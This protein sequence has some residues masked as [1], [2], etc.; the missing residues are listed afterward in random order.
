MGNLKE[1]LRQVKVTG[2]LM[3]VFVIPPAFAQSNKTSHSNS[4]GDVY[5]PSADAIR[6]ATVNSYIKGET[7]RYDA[8]Y[9]NNIN[10]SKKVRLKMKRAADLGTF[11]S[12]GADLAIDGEGPVGLDGN[13]I[14]LHYN[15]IKAERDGR[16]AWG[17]AQTV[18]ATLVYAAEWKKKCIA[19]LTKDKSKLSDANKS[20]TCTLQIGDLSLHHR[21]VDKDTGRCDLGHKS[22]YNGT[23]V[24]VRPAGL[25]AG[26]GQP[27]KVVDLTTEATKFAKSIGAT[28][29]I[30]QAEG[31]YDHFHVC[32]PDR[33]TPDSTLSKNAI[34]KGPLA[35]CYGLNQSKKK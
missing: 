20:K 16:D 6:A 29:T 8:A 14:F 30:W 7:E 15:S 21:N 9:F 34:G 11:E 26:S 5:K 12:W 4:E 17:E 19:K 23:C 31:H 2:L 3:F 13:P 35:G 18:C 25:T 32:F 22:H 28:Y 1:K 24:D 10:D 27:K 33:S